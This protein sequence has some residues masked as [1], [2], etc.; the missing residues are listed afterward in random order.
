[1]IFSVQ[2]HGQIPVYILEGKIFTEGQTTEFKTEIENKIKEGIIN[3]VFDLS[4]ITFVNSAGLN[5][6]LSV[7]TKV[8]LAEGEAIICSVPS[9]MEKLLVITKL[10]SFF[11]T[12]PTIDVAI[13]MIGK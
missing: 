5:F 1:M 7:L 6:L 12:A 9:Q 3:F 2:P 10:H 11:R 4:R 13:G 8:R